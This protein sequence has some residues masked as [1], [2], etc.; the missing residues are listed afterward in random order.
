VKIVAYTKYGREAASTRQRLLQYLPSFAAAGITVDWRPLL[1]DDYVRSL[2]DGSRVSRV[3][4]AGS[5]ARRF[6]QLLKGSDADLVWIY[7]ELFPYLPGVV[8]QLAFRSGLPV[9]YDFDDAFFVPYD[10]NPS[11]TL[12]R[13]LGGKLQPLLKGAAACTCGNAY[14]EQYASRF[15]DRT[16]V[17]PTVVD[18]EIYRPAIVRPD[19]P[20]TIGWIGSPTTWPQVKPLIP[21]LQEICQKNGARFRVIGAGAQAKADQF[22]GLELVE[23]TE[24]REVAE[25]RTMDIG[26]M[27]LTD[28]PFQRGKSGYKLIQY[29]ACAIP[30]VA[31]P[32]GVNSTIVRQGETGFLASVEQE[33]REAL[34]TLA[35]DA[36]LRRRLGEAG[37][38]RAVDYYSLESQAPRLVGL[39]RSLA[40]KAG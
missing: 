17:V 38:V 23:W 29:M 3:K 39:F 14:L 19:H 18:T 27:P 25:V 34:L 22:D 35:G 5:Y 11:P 15:S 20:L 21:L 40:P 36:G 8:E 37:R 12:R 13:I 7:A 32:V 31:S 1:G 26:I 2:V 9:V 4:V 24:Q 10:E 33:W 6:A 16:I 30:V 28:A